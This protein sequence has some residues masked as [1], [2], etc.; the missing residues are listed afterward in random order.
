MMSILLYL[1]SAFFVPT[2]AKNKCSGDA[3]YTQHV[4]DKKIPAGKNKNDIE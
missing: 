3:L 2:V 1:F 4:P